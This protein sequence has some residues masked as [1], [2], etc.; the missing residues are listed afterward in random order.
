MTSQTPSFDGD[1]APRATYR[2]QLNSAFTFADAQRLAPY[3]DALGVS[4]VY[5]SP[6]L[7]ARPGSTHGY[8]TVDHQQI[9]P[10]L[11]SLDDFRALVAAL[12]QHGLGVILDFV[13]NHMGVGGADN[14]LWL[15][16]LKHGPSSRYADWF[17]I[18][19]HPPRPG[20]AGKLLVPF[21]GASYAESLT[22][23][24]LQ[25]RADADGFAIWAGDDQKL[26]I[27]PE[28]ESDL[29]ARHG[30]AEAAIA[31]LSG[32]P[33]QAGS[34]A[35]LDALIARQHWRIAHHSV[36]GDEINY[37][38]FFINSDLAGIRIDRPD[39]FAHAHALIFAL[40][41]EGL[42][43]GLR[44]DHIDGLLDP[45]GYIEKLRE[46]APR[47][48]YLIV[49]KILAPHEQLRG[50]WPVEG[51][52]G[53][54]VGAQLTRILMPAHA[55]P[56][57]TAAYEAFVGA[58]ADP[59][60]EAYRCKLRVMDNE[61]AAELAALA[62]RFATI[63]WAVGTTMDLAEAGLRRALRETIAQL[64]VY[65]VY[66]DDAGSGARDRREIGVA[67]G[68]ARR[69]A[70][71][72]P[73]ALFDFVGD[74]LCGAVGN[75]YDPKLVAEA[76]GRFQQYSGPV[77]AKGLEDTALY[78]YNRLVALNEVGAHPDRFALSVSAFH[79][80]NRRRLATHPACMIATST[81][82]TKRGEDLRAVVAAIAGDPA[83]WQAATQEW[84]AILA[85]DGAD[86]IAANDLYLLF[87][88]LLGGWP[89]EGEA[90]DLADRI[91]AAMT[92]SLREARQRSDWGVNNTGYENGV[93]AFI[94]AALANQAFLRSFHAA[95]LPLVEIG[96][97]KALIQL[98]LKLTIPGV[99][100]IYRGAEDWEQSFV[101]PDNRRPVDFPGLA[102]RLA[103]PMAQRDDKMMLTQT[104]LQLR[105]RLPEVFA[106]GRYEPVVLDPAVL[107][108]RRCHGA[109]EVLVIADL[110]ARHDAGLARWLD[111]VGAPPEEVYR[112]DMLVVFST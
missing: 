71:H 10:E 63:A 66:A 43:D 92:K 78:R 64:E 70:A 99:P 101:D 4:H 26:P 106:Q 21:L 112:S 108:F 28:D 6:I 13:P 54:E 9:N 102:Q 85:A 22:S 103:R 44:I 91:K 25:I 97:R 51:T 79:D 58:V 94:D 7:K 104:L 15:D 56:A 46:C 45:K 12:R 62:R 57:V 11:G 89:I 30:T 87:Q 3:L 49:E 86:A 74:L 109:D 53:Y 88:L 98:G 38:R 60:E 68:K 36:A 59:Q 5:L 40:I 82:D 34:W 90:H 61:L 105:R 48:I 24:H 27:R 81:H 110:S 80:S 107:A 32:H 111:I 47:T 35:A 84:R 8:D 55:E 95:R 17:D 75:E 37:R 65:R 73:P 31:A 2:L 42:V 52:T 14:G 33:E 39:V 96:R 76:V 19:W 29:L 20:M 72:L 23:G 50:D 18:D 1:R 41:A 67:I 93:L 83:R 100:D 69:S 16:V 77:M